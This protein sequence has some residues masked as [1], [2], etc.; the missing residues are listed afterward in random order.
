M[1]LAPRRLHR[2]T[3]MVR[4]LYNSDGDP[5]AYVSGEYVFSARGNFVGKLYPDQQVWNGNYVG[6]IY[7]D[8]RLIYNTEILHGN[9]G[10]PGSPGLP[11]FAGQPAFKGPCTVPLGYNDVDVD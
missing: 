4:W 1:L 3:E 10:V 6:E 9:R 2:E 8:D 5:V 11:G 7:A